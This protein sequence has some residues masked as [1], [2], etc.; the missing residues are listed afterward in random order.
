[1]LSI[2][3]TPLG[4][5]TLSR[6]GGNREAGRVSPIAESYKGVS[7]GLKFRLRPSCRAGAR[8][9]RQTQNTAGAK[10]RLRSISV[11]FLG[12]CCHTPRDGPGI[13]P[14]ISDVRELRLPLGGGVQQRPIRVLV[15]GKISVEGS[16]KPGDYR[17]GTR[18][19]LGC[20]RRSATRN[21]PLRKRS[22]PARDS[23]PGGGDRWVGGA[24]WEMRQ[25]RSHTRAPGSA[26][27]RPRG[28]NGAGPPGALGRRVKFAPSSLILLLGL[29]LHSLSPR[30]SSSL[31]L[32]QLGHPSILVSR[33][34][35]NGAQMTVS[36]LGA[37]QTASQA[38]E[39]KSRY[40]LFCLFNWSE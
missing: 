16:E 17:A 2:W 9:T 26:G 11:S 38:L 39:P 35:S 1:M 20:R 10:P 18:R 3:Q 4:C 28:Q 5:Q 14:V 36:L 30:G 13:C 27:P 33:A 7:W 22:T 37:V 6:W 29:G 23:L 19:R 12:P 40:F 24:Q 15:R 34:R 21:W 25:S 8:T 31:S 32:A